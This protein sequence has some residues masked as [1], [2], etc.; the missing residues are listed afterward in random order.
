VEK[1]ESASFLKKRRPGRGSKK[2]LLLR[3]L[4]P[5]CNE[6]PTRHAGESRHPRL[7]GRAINPPATQAAGT[8]STNISARPSFGTAS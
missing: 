5:A 3:A 8:T 6:G 4:A 1:K 2:L 7:A